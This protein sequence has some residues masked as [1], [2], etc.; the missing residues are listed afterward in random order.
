M[1]KSGFFSNENV[2]VGFGKVIS[3]DGKKFLSPKF[4]FCVDD[5]NMDGNFQ[6]FAFLNFFGKNNFWSFEI[7]TKTNTME[8]F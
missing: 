7:L 3:E 1:N 4:L 8:T 5:E 6:V 2:C